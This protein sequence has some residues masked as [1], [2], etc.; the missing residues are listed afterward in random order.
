[1]LPT[2][3]QD[4]RWDVW[5]RAIFAQ[6]RAQDL[7]EV[8]TA[9]YVPVIPA[10]RSLFEEKQKSICTPLSNVH[11]YPTKE[12]HSFVNIPSTMMPKPFSRISAHTPYNQ[13]RPLSIPAASSPT[14][15]PLSLG[16]G[17]WKGG[18]HAYLPHWQDQVRK[19]E[20]LIPKE[21]HF[22][23]QQKLTMLENVVS[24]IP[25]L[26]QVQI[27]AAHDKVRTGKSITYDQYVSLLLS[28]AMI[29][30]SSLGNIQPGK[31]RSQRQ[32]YR[33]DLHSAPSRD[34]RQI[35]SHDI[36]T[37][38]NYGASSV[39]FDEWEVYNAS[40]DNGPRLSKDQWTCLPPEAHT[41]RDELSPESKHIILEAKTRHSHPR[42]PRKANLHDITRAYL[43]NVAAYDFIQAHLHELQTDD[44]PSTLSEPASN[45][46]SGHS[47][48]DC[49]LNV[50]DSRKLLAHLTKRTTLPPGDLQRVLSSSINKP[51]TT[52][53]PPNTDIHI[54][55]KTYRQVNTAK[56]LYVASD[57]CTVRRGAL[58]DRG[59]NGGIAGDDVR[60]IH[61]SGRQ[62][63]VQGIDNHQIVDI[64]I[65]TAGAV[66]STQRGDVIIIM[67]RYAWTMKGKTI[68]SSGQLEWYKQ[69]VDDK[70]RRVGGKQ[71]IKAIDGYYIPINIQSGLPYV[72]QRPYT[73]SEWNAPLHVVLTSDTE[74][75]QSVLDN[76][77]DDDEEW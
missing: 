42:P 49:T 21:A 64:P 30:D 75:H 56:T 27:Q 47:P 25:D 51:K 22:V 33:H 39:T 60:I 72:S 59:A 35:Y 34:T 17:T 40:Y 66:V 50:D 41:K 16:D 38:V 29:Y 36:D 20:D 63:D 73:G 61:E 12:R 10:D 8:L 70:S 48:D 6:A 45:D 65:V 15:R 13:P 71:W 54:N 26:R 7:I 44:T 11:Y 4:K 67:H 55:G 43:D 57:H 37:D 74:W 19:Y 76:D 28:G 69:D 9:S 23:D 3:K 77:L 68:H 14:S 46:S 24:S 2:L 18:T 58:V 32:V 1:M 52:I 31:S 5:Q 53:P 62:V